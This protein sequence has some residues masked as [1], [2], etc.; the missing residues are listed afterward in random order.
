MKERPGLY[1]ATVRSYR[2]SDPEFAAAEGE[3]LAPVPA[4]LASC[5]ARGG[6]EAV[7]A[8]RGLRSVAHGFGMS[9]DPDESFRRLVRVRRPA[10]PVRGPRGPEG[11]QV[12]EEHLPQNV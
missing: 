9:E 12:R 1:E 6:E 10:A 4:V 5:G 7:H 11:V 2:L 8:A 3:A